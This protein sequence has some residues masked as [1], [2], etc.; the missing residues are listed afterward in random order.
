MCDLEFRV[1]QVD[2]AA[3]ACTAAIVREGVLRR[4]RGGQAVGAGAEPIL[5]LLRM[6][7]LQETRVAAAMDEGAG[8]DAVGGGGP[9]RRG[10]HG[11][12]NWRTFVRNG[13]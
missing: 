9:Y 11:A 10:S 13:G 1:R 5:T 6:P 7:F 4:L 2:R 3:G 8:G 12:C